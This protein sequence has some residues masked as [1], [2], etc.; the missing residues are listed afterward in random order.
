[1]NSD[2]M[3]AARAFVESGL[4]KKLESDKVLLRARETDIL[5]KRIIGKKLVSCGAKVP[6]PP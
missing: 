4:G 1:M 6:P 3:Q 5:A 2:E